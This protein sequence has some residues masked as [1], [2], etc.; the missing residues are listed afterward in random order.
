[1]C[2]DIPFID[3][4]RESASSVNG[5]RY[6]KIQIHIDGR[7]V[8]A[9]GALLRHVE[10]EEIAAAFRICQQQIQLIGKPGKETEGIE[11]SLKTTVIRGFPQRKE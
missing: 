6:F 9:T 5:F 10:M 1:M 2:D 8:P 11:V 7:G 4:R 3:R